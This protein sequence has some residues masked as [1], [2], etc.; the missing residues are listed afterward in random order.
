MIH[1]CTKFELSSFSRL[2]DRRGYKIFSEG[3]V[4]RATPPMEEF[5]ILSFCLVPTHQILLTNRINIGRCVRCYAWLQ[6]VFGVWRFG[7]R[8]KCRQS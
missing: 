1:I 2:V 4:I 8:S 5:Y 7:G 6:D 3:H